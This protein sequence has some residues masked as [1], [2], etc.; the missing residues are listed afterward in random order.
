MDIKKFS[1]IAEYTAEV[2]TR[3][4]TE[5]LVFKVRPLPQFRVAE[6]RDQSDTDRL[7]S[8]LMDAVVDWNLELDGQKIPCDGENKKKYLPALFDIIC[9]DGASIGTGLLSFCGD[10]KN[11]FGE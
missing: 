7:V 11:F 8:L 3:A 2:E 1:A 4:G 9:K 5:R 10:S 6:Y